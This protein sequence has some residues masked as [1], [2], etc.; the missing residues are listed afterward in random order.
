[1]AKIQTDPL[2]NTIECA[3]DL[4]QYISYNDSWDFIHNLEDAK[5]NVDVLVKEAPQ[6]A[7]ILL[8]GSILKRQKSC[9]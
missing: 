4:G 6:R 2:I 7:F 1:M 9:I 3:L 8:R 5:D